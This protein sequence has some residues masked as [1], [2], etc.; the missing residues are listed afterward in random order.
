VRTSPQSAATVKSPSTGAKAQPITTPAVTAT[1][2]GTTINYTWS[3]PSDGVAET[4]QVCIAGACTSYPVPVTG[5]Y[6]GSSSASYGNSQTET[7]TGHLTDTAGQS[8]GTASASATTAGVTTATSSTPPPPPSAA[9]SVSEGSSTT[10][11]SGG[12]AGITCYFF[13]VTA[14]NFP[15]GTA[16]SYTCADSGGVWWGPTSQAESGSTTTNGAGTASF[17]TYCLHANDGQTVTISVSGGGKS[18]PG[19]YKT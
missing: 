7:I 4:L 9:V 8:S 18:A 3:A 12:C 19:S 1:A 11:G 16:L 6:S 5:G 14:T 2:N 10:K 15:A 13:N 17:E